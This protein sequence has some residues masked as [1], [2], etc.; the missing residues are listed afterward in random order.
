MPQGK[1]KVKTK[2]PQNAKVKKTIKK[3]KAVTK[4]ANCPVPSSRTKVDEVRKLK[5]VVTKTVNKS[6]EE[7]IRSRAL[8]KK[9]LS[10]VQEAVAKYHG[11]GGTS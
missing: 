8:D 5:R 10:K 11:E 7:E 4:R 6:I 1:L 2:L 9:S 3:G